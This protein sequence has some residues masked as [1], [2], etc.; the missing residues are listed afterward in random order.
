MSEVKVSNP[1]RLRFIDSM[2]HWAPLEDVVSA[3]VDA[4]SDQ[5]RVYVERLGDLYRWSIVSGSGYPLHRTV[6]AYLGVDYKR[7]YIGFRT[8]QDEVC[9]V[10][11]DPSNFEAPD[12]WAVIDLTP[13]IDDDDEVEA[14]ITSRLA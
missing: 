2:Q 11:E 8:V 10:C 3:V 6:A 5:P 9:I 14:L 7:I 13:S 1:H 4:A 12:A